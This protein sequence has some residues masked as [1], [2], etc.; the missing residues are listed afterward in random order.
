M[1]VKGGR[2]DKYLDWD[3]SWL[4]CDGRS[5]APDADETIH[6]ADAGDGHDRH[7]CGNDEGF[8]VNGMVGTVLYGGV[9]GWIFVPAMS[10]T[11]YWMTGIILGAIGWLIAM[12][13]MMPMAGKGFFGMKIGIIAPALGLFMHI[14]FGVVLGW[15][16]GLWAGFMV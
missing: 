12:V 3:D 13:A 9:F 11:P 6:E 14:F 2:D 1:T 10:G 8:P 4:H 15:V 5:I 16:Y 7:Y